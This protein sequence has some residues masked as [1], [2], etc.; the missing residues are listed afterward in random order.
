MPSKRDDLLSQLFK[1]VDA[2]SLGMFRALF[3]ILLLF[4]AYWVYAPGFVLENYIKPIY[5]FPFSLFEFLRLPRLSFF[6]LMVLF[7]CMGLA[8][9]GITLGLCFRA[10][11]A[12]F[13]ATFLYAF[14]FEK[15]LFYEY[16]YIILLVTF[17]FLVSDAHR[18]PALNTLRV[19]KVRS[20]TIP[21]WQVLVLRF[22]FILIYFYGGLWKLNADWL[23]HAEPMY[24]RI[25]S[26]KILFGASLHNLGLAYLFS[27]AGVIINLAVPVF[28]LFRR[29][30]LTAFWLALVFNL[31]N[32]YLFKLADVRIFPLL[33]MAPFVLFVRP[34]A[35]R[36]FWDKL[37]KR[38]PKLKL[39][40]CKIKI[41]T[42]PLVYP[43]FYKKAVLCF[44]SV[45]AVIQIL[46][47][48]R[49]LVYPGEARW[50][51]E[52][53]RFAWRFKL[54]A[55]DVKM[56]IIAT[57]PATGKSSQIPFEHELSSYQVWLDNVPDML[58]QYTHYVRDELIKMGIKDPVITVEAAASLNGRP[59]QTFIDPT[60]NFAKIEYPP[61][62]HARWILPLE[63]K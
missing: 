55:K 42:D 48:L 31:M 49:H 37:F 47:P 33:M 11:C 50:T 52:G 53:T 26:K 38:F 22:L 36:E 56:K 13:L 28:L 7:N 54:T 40:P 2:S 9:L 30:R 35:P 1:P 5:H 12:V 17:I 45:F 23:L 44:L 19:K 39:P 25:L 57:D 3:G 51:F 46:V 43:A 32:Y 16:N 8:A 21:Y 6:Q 60:V 24:S 34:E 29:T 18:W 63:T 58:V 59:Y 14:L 27:Y 62:S 61:F 4:Q 41:S 20:Q 10:S 15:A